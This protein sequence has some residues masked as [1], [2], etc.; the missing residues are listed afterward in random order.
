MLLGLFSEVCLEK[1][2][3]PSFRNI[4]KLPVS[5][6]VALQDGLE[7]SNGDGVAIICTVLQSSRELV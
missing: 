6:T 4:W 2:Q 1:I 3:S 7:S 5:S